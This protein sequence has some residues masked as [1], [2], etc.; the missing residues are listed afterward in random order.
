MEKKSQH[1][2][3]I[4]TELRS[5]RHSIAAVGELK[6]VTDTPDPYLI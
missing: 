4:H 1:Q 5:E 3:E 2:K 6:Q